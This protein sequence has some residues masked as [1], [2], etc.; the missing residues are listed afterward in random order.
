MK[1]SRPR[2]FFAQRCEG[3]P[4][5]FDE[6]AAAQA[7]EAC[8][9][10]DNDRLNRALGGAVYRLDSLA[11]YKGPHHMLCPQK[12]T[13]HAGNFVPTAKSP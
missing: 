12:A 13:A 7:P 9:A 4:H 11:L 10:M 6:A 2:P 3:G 1:T 8:L 5:P